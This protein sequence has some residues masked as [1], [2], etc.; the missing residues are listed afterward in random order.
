[1]RLKSNNFGV[2]LSGKIGYHNQICIFGYRSKRSQFIKLVLLVP[3]WYQNWSFEEGKRKSQS[4]NVDWK[5]IIAVFCCFFRTLGMFIAKP[6]LSYCHQILRGRMTKRKIGKISTMLST[7]VHTDANFNDFVWPS[8][9]INIFTVRRKNIWTISVFRCK[10]ALF[11][12]AW[13]IIKVE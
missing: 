12:K 6:Q 3:S 11:K 9:D 4:Q 13:P 2:V 10:M 5:A 1:M 8:T 7:T